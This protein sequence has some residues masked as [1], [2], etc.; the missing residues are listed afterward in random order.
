MTVLY[1]FISISNIHWLHHSATSFCF[2]GSCYTC[3]TSVVICA[4][5]QG[6]QKHYCSLYLIQ[7]IFCLL[8]LP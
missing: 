8:P 2:Q 6:R 1:C 5:L 7:N 4:S 3:S